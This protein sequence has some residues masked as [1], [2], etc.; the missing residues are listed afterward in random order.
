M[1]TFLLTTYKTNDIIFRIE[2]TDHPTKPYK[3]HINDKINI[4]CDEE[5]FGSIVGLV[6]ENLDEEVITERIV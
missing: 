6:L 3:I 4:N 5:S 2:L 1:K